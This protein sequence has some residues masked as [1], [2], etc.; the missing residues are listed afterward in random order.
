[1]IL[2]VCIGHSSQLK[3][4]KEMY[5]LVTLVPQRL[6]EARCSQER[7]WPGE[8]PAA[9]CDQ[10]LHTHSVQTEDARCWLDFTSPLFKGPAQ[11]ECVRTVL[12]LQ[13]TKKAVQPSVS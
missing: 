12:L 8:P 13:G 1:M 11:T 7:L 10:L 5:S 6:R 9:P 4:E 2:Q 3:K